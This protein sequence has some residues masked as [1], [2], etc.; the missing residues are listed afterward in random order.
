[1]LKTDQCFVGM[2]DILGFKALRKNIGTEGLY[3]RFKSGI[4]PLIQHAAAGMGKYEIVDGE[5][6][7]IP[8]FNI[9]SVNYLI[10]SDT[11]IFFTRDSSFKSFSNI[12]N[13]SFSLLQSGFIGSKTPFRGSI[14]IGDLIFDRSGII[15]GSAIED[16]YLGESI[17]EWSGVMLT[18]NC[19]EFVGKEGYP[20]QYKKVYLD[21]AENSNIEKEK[22]IAKGNA[23]CLVRYDVPLKIKHHSDQSD[24]NVFS[25]LVI[26][27]TVRMYKDASIKAFSDTKEEHAEQIIK[28]TQAFENWARAQ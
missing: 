2:Y 17:Q 11:I 19:L 16:A 14:E 21:I 26:N 22:R 8:Q 4:L 7:F 12:V 1:M 18:K 28:N 27:W 10:I 20:D 25:T 13:S 24:S 6:V 5:N 23:E 9:N 15:I 3:E